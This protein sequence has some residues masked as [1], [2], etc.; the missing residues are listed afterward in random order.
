MRGILGTSASLWSDLSLISVVLLAGVAVFGAVRAR[1][2]RFSTH[3]PVMAIAALA[4]WVPVLLLMIPRWLSVVK[5]SESLLSGS[6]VITPIVHGVL[7]LVT[8][9]LMTYTV[10]RM[11]WIEQLPPERPIWLMRITLGL[12][13]LTV[14]GGIGVY[15]LYVI[16]A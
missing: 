5:R 10:T 6:L 2:R 16:G 14:I 7:G 1:Q 11:Y 8:Q 9:S 15:V 4:N 13:L 3:C 12:W